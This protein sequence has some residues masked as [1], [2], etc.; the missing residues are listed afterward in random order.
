MSE[1]IKAFVVIVFG[2]LCFVLGFL[3]VG[4]W[5]LA[6]LALGIAWQIAGQAST[7]KR[8]QV[9]A[10][11]PSCI[12]SVPSKPTSTMTWQETVE[13]IELERNNQKS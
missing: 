5:M 3:I 7:P 10:P 2:G 13:R 12:A 6:P 9:Q 4:W 11:H 1:Q 8:K